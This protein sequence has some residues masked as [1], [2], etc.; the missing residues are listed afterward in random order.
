MYLGPHQR[1]CGNRFASM[2]PSIVRNA[3]DHPLGAP[4]AVWLQSNARMRS[5]ISPSPCR[6][7]KSPLPSA[8]NLSV[9]SIVSGGGKEDLAGD[10]IRVSKPECSFLQRQ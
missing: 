1:T 6:K 2:I 3:G 7:A 10:S 4:I 5:L 9:V 8:E